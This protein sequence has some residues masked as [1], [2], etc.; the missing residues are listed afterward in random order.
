MTDP[1]YV[2]Q[3]LIAMPG[4]QDPNFETTVTL[5]C[6][7]TEE[8]ALGIVIN[9]PLE[10]RLREVLEQLS[11]STEDEA[12]NDSRVLAGGPVGHE[13]GFVVHGGDAEWEATL[14]LSDEIR[15]TFSKDILAAIASGDGPGNAM[16]ALGY[17]GWDAGQLESEMMAN[18]WLNVTAT[19]DILFD[20]PYDQRWQAAAQRLGIDIT[21]LAS[22]AGHA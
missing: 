3:L 14:T 20:V 8:G 2:N 11:L 6:E 4:M 19:P 22:D 18:A 16:V 5:I 9:R 1:N 15:V 10:L 7:H 21:R 13:R 12:I 17:A